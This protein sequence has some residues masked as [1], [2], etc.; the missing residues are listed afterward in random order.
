[1]FI[2]TSALIYNKYHRISLRQWEMMKLN[3]LVPLWEVNRFINWNKWHTFYS[4]FYYHQR[5]AVQQVHPHQ[6]EY[7]S[8]ECTQ[9]LLITQAKKFLL[10]EMHLKISSAKQRPFCSCLS[11]LR[12]V[13]FVATTHSSVFHDHTRCYLSK[14]VHDIMTRRGSVVSGIFLT[15][16]VIKHNPSTFSKH[17]FHLCI[18]VT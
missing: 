9:A 16:N 11:V 18:R 4:C 5:S 12:H 1:M 3:L 15:L 14:M 8:S 10:S 6:T 7:R 13:L 17:Y 2:D